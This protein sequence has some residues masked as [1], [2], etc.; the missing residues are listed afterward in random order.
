MKKEIENKVMEILEK[1]CYKDERGYFYSEIYRDYRDNLTEDLLKEIFNSKNPKDKFFELMDE[2]YFYCQCEIENELIDL[3][4]NEVKEAFDYEIDCEEVQDFLANIGYYVPVPYEDFLKEEVCVNIVVDC[5]D[6]EYD[7]SINGNY[8]N[9]Y[10]EL[11]EESCLLWLGKKQGYSREQIEEA[12]LTDKEIQGKF[13]KSLYNELVNE[14]TCMNALTFFVKM[15]L[16]DLLDLKEKKNSIILDK[17]TNCGLIDYWNGAGSILGIELEKDITIN[18][19]EIGIIEA[20]G[21]SIGRYSV[22]SIYGCGEDLW[23]EN[24][25]KK[26]S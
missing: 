17:S 22:Y 15:T 7:Y 24:A 2:G 12:L 14:T 8:G 25:I 5:G 23:S 19:D 11:E 13:M 20:D 1:E 6:W 16:K 21:S 3:I 26:V 18:S 10:G 9:L 4:I